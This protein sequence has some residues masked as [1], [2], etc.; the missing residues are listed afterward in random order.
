VASKVKECF[1][2]EKGLA[3]G[4]KKAPI[5]DVFKLA[6]VKKVSVVHRACMHALAACMNAPV[7][8]DT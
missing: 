1:M 8:H 4:L 3:G 6:N 7:V 5:E 2:G